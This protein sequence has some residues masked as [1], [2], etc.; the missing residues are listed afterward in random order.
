MA[1][2]LLGAML[3][4]SQIL[5]GFCGNGTL[6]LRS[7]GTIC[8]VH[9][10]AEV[11]H[12]CEKDHGQS[13]CSDD[14]HG[15]SHSICAIADN[16]THETNDAAPGEPCPVEQ[17]ITPA[18]PCGCRHLPISSGSVPS[19]RHVSVVTSIQRRACCISSPPI[20]R[21]SI[22]RPAYTLSGRLSLTS[23]RC[24]TI[25]LTIASSTV[26]RC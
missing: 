12:C 17:P 21:I 5:T 26:I 23:P 8:C 9:D 10:L 19:A 16:D 24:R 1:R 7:D 18:I 11:C 3:I 4:A 25:G 20:D 6:C 13:R 2:C 14:H 15:H 22:L